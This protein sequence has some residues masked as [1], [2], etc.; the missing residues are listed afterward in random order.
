MGFTS[1]NSYL[2]RDLFRPHDIDPRKI[3]P[4]D[5]Q[6]VYRLE[7]QL[8]HHVW[9]KPW[10]NR[11]IQE[12]TNEEALYTSNFHNYFFPN[13]VLDLDNQYIFQ[14]HIDSLGLDFF[15]DVVC[16]FS[17]LS[18]LGFGYNHNPP[19]PASL[20][21]L[22]KLGNI[23]L[24]HNEYTAIPPILWEMKSVP[25]VLLYDNLISTLPPDLSEIT[26]LKKL[27]LRGNPLEDPSNLPKWV[28]YF[29]P[30]FNNLHS[31]K[32][33]VFRPHE[34]DPALI[35][36]TELESL[37]AFEDQIGYPVYIQ[38]DEQTPFTQPRNH[39]RLFS[40]HVIA[41][42]I[43]NSR[44][45]SLP[46]SIRNLKKLQ[47]LQISNLSNPNIPLFV[48]QFQ[49]L[50]YLGLSKNEFHQVPDVILE[51]KSV[52]HLNLSENLL[53]ILPSEL[54]T[55]S[56][57]RNL[58]LN[59]NP[60]RSLSGI[61]RLCKLSINPWIVPGLRRGEDFHSPSM[62]IPM[63]P[64]SLFYYQ[65]LS[66]VVTNFS[67]W[68]YSERCQYPSLA[69]LDEGG[70]QRFLHFLMND[71]EISAYIPQQPEFESL[72]REIIQN[73]QNYDKDSWREYYKP[74][75]NDLARKYAAIQMQPDQ[76][77]PSSNLGLTTQESERLIYEAD[78]R[79]FSYLKNLCSHNDPIVLEI[80]KR[81]QIRGKNGVIHL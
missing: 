25:Y 34:I 26:W 45:K 72:F 56:C 37:R 8:G 13:V 12:V 33:A 10:E 14:I 7:E 53:T 27:G 30:S 2:K 6:I 3:D 24:E 38:P 74:H 31:R 44:V 5:L 35:D 15:P 75:P 43:R 71:C 22:K 21:K 57:L 64:A 70:Q 1:R 54:A 69:D 46:E 29:V 42:H 81:F 55:V 16:E 23:T 50:H 52:K 76:S 73:C 78:Y 61:P 47:T 36:K 79:I 32:L 51:L 39:I 80:G 4:A 9:I 63:W 18:A 68:G 49:K 66:R 60:L 48:S 11:G 28:E 65:F 58:D 62:T 20:L 17:H 19:L 77:D 59:S 41:A 40:K 67:I